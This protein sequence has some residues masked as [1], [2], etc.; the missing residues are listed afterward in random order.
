LKPGFEF[1]RGEKQIQKFTKNYQGRA[2]PWR[3]SQVA[4]GLAQTKAETGTKLDEVHKGIGSSASVCASSYQESG[5]RRLHARLVR[6]R[7]M[8]LRAATTG[9]GVTNLPS[10][11]NTESS[12]VRGSRGARISG[13]FFRGRE[14][15]CFHEGRQQISGSAGVKPIV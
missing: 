2:G 7:E 1:R 11:T 4:E 14:S 5:P 10:I 9:G 13:W 15:P 3:R 8:G 12:D 6:G